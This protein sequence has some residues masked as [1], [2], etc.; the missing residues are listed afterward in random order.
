MTSRAAAT[1]TCV[2]EQLFQK[3]FVRAC[4][5]RRAVQSLVLR[6]NQIVFPPFH[7]LR[8]AG[9]GTQRVV[10]SPVLECSFVHYTRLKSRRSK[11]PRPHACLRCTRAW[12]GWREVVGVPPACTPPVTLD[13][14]LGG[15][16]VFGGASQAKDL[17]AYSI[18]CNLYQY[19]DDRLSNNQTRPMRLFLCSYALAGARSFAFPLSAVRSAAGGVVPQGARKA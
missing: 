2:L 14:A 16:P 17:G 7:P 9:T 11:R 18:Y 4:S 1:R 15:T 10:K 3:Q 8:W 5:R 6:T 13:G 12:R 19:I